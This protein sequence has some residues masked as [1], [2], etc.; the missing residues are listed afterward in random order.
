MS[1]T[2]E[3]R[4]PGTLVDGDLELVLVEKYPGDPGIGFVPAYRF[5]MRLRG[6]ATKVGDIDLRVGYTNHLVMYGGQIGYTVLPQH[7]GHRYA[8]RACK[9][10]FPLARSHD[11][12]TLWV[13]CNPDNVAS[14]RTLE[15]A[16]GEL[17]EIVDVPEDTD[18]YRRGEHQKCRYR[19]EL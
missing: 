13:S 18:I 5:E 11:M 4:N 8:A 1:A 6:T 17:V 9:L 3:F 2:F 14:R 16:R 19:F 12:N 15:L 10:L 7:R